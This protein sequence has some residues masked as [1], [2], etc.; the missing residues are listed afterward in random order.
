MYCPLL[1]ILHTAPVLVVRIVLGALH[2]ARI[3]VARATSAIFC[4]RSM[5]AHR[6][7]S[8]LLFL[9]RLLRV[10]SLLEGCAAEAALCCICVLF[11]DCSRVC[12]SALVIALSLLLFFLYLCIS[13]AA[14]LS[15]LLFWVLHAC[16]SVRRGAAFDFFCVVFS[17]PRNIQQMYWLFLALGLW[18]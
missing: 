17:F 16:M 9:F 12:S 6:I 13:A 3:R 5:C 2:Y 8:Y 4:F 18:V 15:S 7:G 14:S 11:V 10:Y 1:I